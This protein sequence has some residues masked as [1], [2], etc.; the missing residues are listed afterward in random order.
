MAPLA[1]L[2]RRAAIKRI[3]RGPL[4]FAFGSPHPCVM[5]LEQ[6]GVFRIRE[7]V[8]D[9]TEAATAS[10]DALANHRS[11]MPEHAYALGRPVGKIYAEAVSRR[12]LAGQASKMD[13]PE[14]W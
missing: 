6:D 9:A 2:G 7:L 11:W 5:V 3:R 13:W 12:K 1:P 10:A 8:I 14:H 4:P